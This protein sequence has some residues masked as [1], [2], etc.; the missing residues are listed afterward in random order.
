MQESSSKS[1]QLESF[2]NILQDIGVLSLGETSNVRHEQ[3]EY[4]N[5]RI[6]LRS[7]SNV[8]LFFQPWAVIWLHSRV[9][10]ENT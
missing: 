4:S 6:S 1:E 10:V 5:G 2:A 7:L 8:N 9:L 3:Q